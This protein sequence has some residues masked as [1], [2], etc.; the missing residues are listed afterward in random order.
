MALCILQLGYTFNS[1]FCC[2]SGHNLFLCMCLNGRFMCSVSLALWP[3]VDEVVPRPWTPVWRV[4]LLNSLTG[5]QKEGVWGWGGLWSPRGCWGLSGLLMRGHLS[6]YAPWTWPPLPPDL[7][8]DPP[9]WLTSQF[10]TDQPWPSGQ[11]Y[12]VSDL[13]IRH[14]FSHTCTPKHTSINGFTRQ[15]SSLLLHLF[16]YFYHQV[17]TLS[18]FHVLSWL[19]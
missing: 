2:I 8:F 4:L 19:M 9:N 11:H 14:A 7:G 17:F 3:C 12:V 16:R 15:K 13:C 10:P 6:P 5:D 1:V 18:C